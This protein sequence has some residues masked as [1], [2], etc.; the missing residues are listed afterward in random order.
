MLPRNVLH[1]FTARRYQRS[2]TRECSCADQ[3][4][5]YNIGVDSGNNCPQLIRNPPSEYTSSR[6]Q[7]TF[8][9][10]SANDIHKQLVLREILDEDVPVPSILT[11]FR[12][13]VELKGDQHVPSEEINKRAV[14]F[15]PL[16]LKNVALETYSQLMLGTLKYRSENT[17]AKLRVPQID[18]TPVEP[19]TTWI[20]W[21]E[22]LTAMFA[23]LNLLP[24]ICR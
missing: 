11:Q 23:P 5:H 18:V 9:R 8:F 15:L 10:M 14:H 13:R 17:L 4:S 2:T 7:L 24:N 22:A 19:Q 20:D 6:H 21:V 12:K 16:L 1:S 3:S